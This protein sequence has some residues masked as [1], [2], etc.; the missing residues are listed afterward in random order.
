MWQRVSGLSIADRPNAPLNF[1]AINQ[2]GKLP[3]AQRDTAL[4]KRKDSGLFGH[5]RGFFGKNADQDAVLDLKDRQGRV[6]LRL[7]VTAD[8]EAAIDFLN[9]EG[10][11]VK[12]ERP[13]S[14]KLESS[15]GHS[16]APV[17]TRR[18]PSPR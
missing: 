15:S 2:L 13:P 7:R 3:L 9:A 12:R 4:Q 18:N 1:E 8:G 14:T 11:V 10:R 17:T 16:D 6:R 5:P